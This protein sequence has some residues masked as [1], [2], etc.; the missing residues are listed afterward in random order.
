MRARRRA[1]ATR[2]AR[3]RRS[4]E[5]ELSSDEHVSYSVGQWAWKPWLRL[6]LAFSTFTFLCCRHVPTRPIVLP[7]PALLSDC[8]A[9]GAQNRMLLRFLLLGC[10]CLLSSD[11]AKGAD[12]N[13][14]AR[15]DRRSSDE[16]CGSVNGALRRAW[17]RLAEAAAGDAGV[18]RESAGPVAR[19]VSSRLAPAAGF[20]RRDRGQRVRC[21]GGLQA[22][23]TMSVYLS[24]LEDSWIRP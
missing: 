12:D 18:D 5:H 7:R 8:A 15:G 16:G 23:R 1:A 22:L 21:C 9:R 6:V 14:P 4:C 19:M 17:S 10:T 24:F 13:P 2:A 11:W 20:A 3:V